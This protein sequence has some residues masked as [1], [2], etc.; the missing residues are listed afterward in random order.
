MCPAPPKRRENKKLSILEGKTILRKNFNERND[1]IFSSRSGH[2]FGEDSRLL[3]N[4]MQLG[5]PE[6]HYALPVVFFIRQ[7]GHITFPLA[8]VR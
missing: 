6:R 7:P 2:F 1:R 5:D 8:W 4:V 3:A